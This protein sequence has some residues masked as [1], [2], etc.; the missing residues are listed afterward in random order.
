[1][2][3]SSPKGARLLSEIEHPP[4]RKDSSNVASNST[5]TERLDSLLT[6]KLKN[7]QRSR[8][9]SSTLVL[10][11]QEYVTSTINRRNILGKVVLVLVTLLFFINFHFIL[12]L[13]I[14][15]NLKLSQVKYQDENAN[16]NE[17]SSSYVDTNSSVQNENETNYSFEYENLECSADLGT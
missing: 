16:H 1:M 12:F 6:F 10:K 13:Q 4:S 8:Y 5:R 11:A 17:S 9:N 3:F 7:K 2:Y 14:K 15:E